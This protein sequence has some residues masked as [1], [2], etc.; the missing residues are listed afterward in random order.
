MKPSGAGL[1][2][3]TQEMELIFRVAVVYDDPGVAKRAMNT[4]QTLALQLSHDAGFRST[5]WNAEMLRDERFNQQA[6]ED[7]ADAD[8]II[9]AVRRSHELLEPMRIWMA[10]WIPKKQGQS[11]VLVA[12]LDLE[13]PDGTRAATSHLEHE[14]EQAAARAGIDYLQQRIPSEKK[15]AFASDYSLPMEGWG[16]ND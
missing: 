13:N 5:V 7:A 14:L 12:L 16:I 8:M 11:S 10:G 4:C 1:S 6:V 9:V 15:S 3:P 2:V